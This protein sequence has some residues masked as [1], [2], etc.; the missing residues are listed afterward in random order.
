M[1]RF[2]RRTPSDLGLN[3]LA[4]ARN[5]RGSI[6]FDL[7]ISNPTLCRMPY[8]EDL[9]QGLS[10]PRGLDYEPLPRGGHAAREAIAESYVQ[11]GADV[12]PD[13]IVLTASTSEAYS[14]LFRLLTEPGDRILVPAPSYPLFEQLARLDSVGLVHYSLEHEG[15]WRVDFST[16]EDAGES[17]RAVVVVH[18]NNPTGSFVHP[19]DARRLEALCRDRN[20]ALVADEVFL[21][22]P[23]EAAPGAERSFVETR[24]C[25]SFSLGGLSK[26]VGL[27]QV[28]LAWIAV[29]GPGPQVVEALERLDYVSD[30][31]LS[32]STPV[33]L[34]APE[35]IDRGQLIRDA[36][37]ARC[38]SNLERVCALAE[39]VPSVTVLT[40]QGGW[41]VV[42]R[43][44]AVMDEEE[45]AVT[46]L[47]RDGVAV[48]PGY[49]FGF[50][51]PG[52]LV[53][54]LLPPEE[55]FGE[56]VR[57]ILEAIRGF[58]P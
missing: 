53:L 40:P 57:R 55:T 17:C 15:G 52:Q 10:K 50:R 35:L 56:G 24:R 48:Y 19:D 26:S 41:N 8:P 5:G 45:F 6:P 1:A 28:K 9:L 29:S 7:T 23:L 32:A 21:P 25:L 43:Y 30:A 3:R 4:A 18:P 42:I 33:I 46:L 27:P 20:W 16:L 39:E 11:W 44:P 54:S 47:E 14:F 22:Y 49:L 31:Y 58:L 37:S 34:A 2:S 36:I 13:R 12:S 38:S 51:S